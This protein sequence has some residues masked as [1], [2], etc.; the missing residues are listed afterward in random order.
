[1]RKL[2]DI[3]IANWRYSIGLERK[4]R[5]YYYTDM[6]YQTIGHIPEILIRNTIVEFRYVTEGGRHLKVEK[7]WNDSQIF[8]SEG[9]SIFKGFERQDETP[10][11]PIKRFFN[12]LEKQ[13][14]DLETQEEDARARE[15]KAEQDKRDG[16]VR[17][18]L[19][20]L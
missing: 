1:M 7:A 12:Y 2:R 10:S 4:E 18:L 9:D 16:L 11:G 3:P 5:G 13:R 14:K 19:E 20:D 15:A 17:K 6:D 8:I